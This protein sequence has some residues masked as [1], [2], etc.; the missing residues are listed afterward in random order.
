[1][2][3]FDVDI[4]ILSTGGTAKLL[5]NNDVAVTEVLQYTHFLK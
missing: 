3:C 4:E 5:L 2:P 1:L